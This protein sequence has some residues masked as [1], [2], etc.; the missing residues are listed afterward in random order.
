MPASP[1]RLTYRAR[2]V[3]RYLGLVI[4]VQFLLWTLGGLYFSWTSLDVVHG[5]HLLRPQGLL[6]ADVP[7]ASPALAVANLRAREPVDSLAGVELVRVLGRPVYRLQYVARGATRRTQLAD[8]ATGALRPAVG[9]DEAVAVARQA[10]A[11]AAPVLSVEYLTPETVGRHHE[12]REQPLPAWA[13]TFDHPERATA[14]V[15][16][17]LGRVLRVRNDRW[18]AFDFLWMLHTMDYQ[19]RDDINNLVLRG[20]SVLG[21]AT[22]LSGFTLFGLTS[23][24]VVRRRRRRSGAAAA[25]GEADAGTPVAAD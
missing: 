3:H 6:P 17:E 16:A 25:R 13:V 21:L 5:D 15:P 7:L 9:R 8:A 23:P 19:G 1:A 22:V 24:P 20:F 12:Y 11:G 18:R 4:G 2:R 10:F 14:Y